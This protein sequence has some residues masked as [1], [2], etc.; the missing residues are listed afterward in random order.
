VDTPHTPTDVFSLILTL[1]FSTSFPCLCFRCGIPCFD[2]AGLFFPLA[3]FLLFPSLL[4]WW[5]EEC[6][7]LGF[8]MDFI[9]V[10]CPRD[11]VLLRSSSLLLTYYTHH[12]SRSAPSPRKPLFSWPYEPANCVHFCFFPWFVGELISL[13]KILRV[14]PRTL[15]RLL[16]GFV[17][18]RPET[19]SPL[20][21]HGVVIPY[22]S[23]LP[24]LAAFCSS[25]SSI[26]CVLDSFLSFRD[27]FIQL[28]VFASSR[29]RSLFSPILFSS[30]FYHTLFLGDDLVSRS[31]PQGWFSPVFSRFLAL[32]INSLARYRPQISYPPVLQLL[33][34]WTSLCLELY[35]VGSP[36][37]VRLSTPWKPPISL[38]WG[39][40]ALP[41]L[42]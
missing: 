1:R 5:G 30:L 33:W 9:F 15:G 18:L 42:G 21:F 27:F 29:G 31:I 19:V 8:R 38:P 40:F 16:S 12:Q 20:F 41:L 24:F 6:S 36:F 4:L 2:A 25:F 14:L 28:S 39:G 10:F 35:S 32:C 7:F 3:V 22:P 23:G 17:A 11:W 37:S 13:P 34:I 26:Y